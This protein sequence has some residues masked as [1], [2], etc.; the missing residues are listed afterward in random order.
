VA[1]ITCEQHGQARPCAGCAADEA[2]QLAYLRDQ[3]RIARIFGERVNAAENAVKALAKYARHEAD[4]DKWE[5]GTDELA[6]AIAGA[7]AAAAALRG[8]RRIA[9]LYASRVRADLAEAKREA[10]RDA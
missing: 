7:E 9:G 8:V 3:S 2:G 5:I 10:G 6:D 1:D 4:G